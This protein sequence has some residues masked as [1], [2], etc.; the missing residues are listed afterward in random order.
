MISEDVDFVDLTQNRDNRRAV[1]K[2]LMNLG[3]P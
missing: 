1:V 2:T 3:F